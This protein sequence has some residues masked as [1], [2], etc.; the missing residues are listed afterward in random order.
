MLAGIH[1]AGEESGYGRSSKS[2]SETWG[3]ERHR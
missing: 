1:L 3:S 2:R